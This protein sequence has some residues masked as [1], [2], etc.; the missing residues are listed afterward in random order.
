MKQGP[1]L[2][3]VLFWQ[4]E[5]THSSELIGVS[6]CSHTPQKRERIKTDPVRLASF[7]VG[8]VR[9]SQEDLERAL[10]GKVTAHHRFL[11]GEHLRQI[12][13]L[14]EAIKRVSEEIAR[15][16]TPP[17]PPTEDEPNA[18]TSEQSVEPSEATPFPQASAPLGWQEAIKL[19]DEITGISEQVAQGLL[20]E[21]GVNMDQFPSA[22]H[23]ASRVGIVR[24]ITRLNIPG[25]ARKNSKGGSWV[26]GLP[27]VERQRG[28]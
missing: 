20:A 22:K 25:T 18:G 24:C 12:E 5:L 1:F 26:T 17:E 15:R 9:A 27:G 19:V 10:T 7:A 11:L 2:W 13:H 16:F 23:L 28:P 21:I 6:F 3:T 14:D 4:R 8:P